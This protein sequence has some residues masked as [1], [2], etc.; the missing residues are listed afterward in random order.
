M[1]ISKI[2]KIMIKDAK[3]SIKNMSLLIVVA[4]AIFLPVMMSFMMGSITASGNETVSIGIYDRG[5]NRDYVEYLMSV[6]LYNV[7]IYGSTDQINQSIRD[8]AIVGGIDVPAGFDSD[9]AAK[10]RPSLVL[11]TDS[12]NFKSLIFTESCKELTLRY[13]GLEYPVILQTQ[14]VVEVPGGSGGMGDAASY[15]GFTA[16]TLLLISIII[17]GVSVLPATLTTEKEKK[18][19]TALMATPVTQ[20]DV[21]MGK[22]LFGV[23]VT[24]LISVIVLFLSNSITGNLPLAAVFVLL[25]AV[26]FN[27][28]GLLISIYSNSYQTASIISSVIM[29]PLMLFTFLYTFIDELKVVGS[30]LPN[31]YLMNGLNDAIVYNKDVST[32]WVNLLV[33]TAITVVIYAVIYVSL[34]RK[35]L[36]S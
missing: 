8:G 1:D 2:F 9:I 17:V 32:Q 22:S 11:L 30:V 14:S 28:I 24:V 33:F 4:I 31:V 7:S 27:G 29:T 26:A 18:T 34:R 15:S 19:I 35:G 3:L 10:N 25:G 12:T 23:F 21:I 6:P 20:M 16:P 36:A 13:A 5:D